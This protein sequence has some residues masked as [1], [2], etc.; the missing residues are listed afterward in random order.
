MTYASLLERRSKVEHGS[1]P[2]ICR[3]IRVMR[4]SGLVFGLFVTVSIPLAG[5]ITVTTK[6]LPFGGLNQDYTAQL[7]ATGGSG[8]YSWQISAG[9]PPPGI[10]FNQDTGQ[11]S[12]APTAVG[13]FSFTVKVF[14]NQNI[15]INATKQL[16][17]GVM[18]ISN[19]SELPNGSTCAPYSQTFLIS[20]GPPPPFTWSFGGDSF[21]PPGL[22]LDSNTG[23]LSG[24]PATTGNFPFTIIAFSPSANIFATKDFSLIVAGLCFITTS[25]PN[26][27][28][29]SFYR[30]SVVITGGTAPFAWKVQSGSLPTG[31]TL[32][33]ASGLLS[34]T[35]TTPGPYSFTIQVTDHDNATSTQLYN[36]TINPAL[37]FSSKSPLPPGTAGAVYSQTLAG[38]GGMPPYV[39]TSGNLPT[40]LTLSAAGVLSG[41]AGAGVFTITVTLTDSLHDAVNMDFQLTIVSAGPTLQVSPMA[42]TFTVPF[43][44]DAPPPQFIDVVPIGTQP[45][46]FQVGIDGGAAGTP[47]PGWIS[48]KPMDPTAP[49]RLVVNVNQGTMAAQTSNARVLIS[50]NSGNIT[51]VMVTLNIVSASPQL[52]VVPDTL[53]FAARFAAPGTLV[54]SLGIRSTGGGGPMSFTTSVQGNSTWVSGVT[55]VS[56]R[57][58]PNSTVFVNVQVSTLGLQIGSYHDV[59]VFT[60]PAGTIKVPVALFVSG[61]GAILGLSVT[62]IRFQAR[63]GGGFSNAQTVEVL[64]IGDPASSLAW[65]AEFVN[66]SQFFTATPTSGNATPDSPGILTLTPNAN[67]LQ[68]TAGGYYGLLKIS[69]SQALN[70]PLYVVLVL[71]LQNSASPPLPDPSPAGLVF[72]AT[73]GKPLSV[74]QLV[75]VN[76]SSASAA[77]FQVATLT[78]DGGT[79]L[80]ANPLTGTSTG[81]TPGQVTITVDASQLAAGIYSGEVDISMSGALRSVNIILI[82]LPGS[83]VAAH[84]VPAATS[85]TPAKLALAETGLVNNFSVPAGWPAALTVQLNDDCGNAV[86]NGSVTASFSNGDPPLMLRPGQSPSYSATWQPGVVSPQMTV[87]LQAQAG[88]L[89]PAT[90]QLIGSINQNPN[91]PPVLS[92]NGTVNVFNRVPAGALAPG[93][94]IEVYGAGLATAKGNPG[95]LPLPTSFQGTSLIVGPDEAPLYFVSGGQLDVQVA[96]ELAPNQQYPVIA[97]LNGALSVPVMADIAPIQ[98]G[99]A[100]QTDGT[101][102]AQHGANSAYVTATSPA[103]P[104]EVLV[105]YLSGM[106][107]TNPSV[108]SGKPAPGSEPLARVTIPPTVSLDGQN[109]TVQFAGLTPGLVGLYQINFQVPA[110]ART[111]DLTLIVSQNGVSSNPTRLAVAK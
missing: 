6:A 40:G 62:G 60:S 66:G 4:L 108:P 103:K 57:T 44:G 32:D 30:Q 10:F 93:M 48:V 96:A 41:S 100:A 101:V 5:Q 11:F 16:S 2:W 83:T 20:D 25:L 46:N 21:T 42:L 92:E 49:A 33:P 56:G 86:S 27:D 39:F 54:Q 18:Q 43:E 13:T 88:A 85:C 106:G 79:W 24:T 67:V 58:V 15:N 31:V 3:R 75:N 45:I 37:A 26:G 50:D 87:T 84:A 76:T 52:Q 95:V 97:I 29:N 53:H 72:I 102:I 1:S 110:N 47:A 81:Q 22:N 38:T 107:P 90:S 14:D 78:A 73:A 69:S 55:P 94:I 36:V 51:I 19:S 91:A 80:T 111:G 28:A 82:V 109:A 34:G 64:D 23:V 9:N 70:S 17:I 35:P 63:Q 12:N 71:D 74:G 104:G 99:I 65:S 59:I 61:N 105:I 98:L 68:N 89:T 7:T 77:A 8:N